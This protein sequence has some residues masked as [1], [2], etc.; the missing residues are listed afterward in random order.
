[1][2]SIKNLTV[3]QQ[4]NMAAAGS[5]ALKL[6]KTL[7]PKEEKKSIIRYTYF[8]DKITVKSKSV[9]EEHKNE[10]IKLNAKAI[11]DLIEINTLSHLIKTEL[12]WNW[13]KKIP[14]DDI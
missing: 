4:G 6:E 5:D 2:R 12:L 14:K 3:H 11:D 10:K 13:F 7:T 9:L 1:M 8:A